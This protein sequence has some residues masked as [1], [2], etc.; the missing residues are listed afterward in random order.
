MTPPHRSPCHDC[1]ENKELTKC[2]KAC[3]KRQLYVDSF[4][5]EDLMKAVDTEDSY[6][7]MPM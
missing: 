5:G 7:L 3:E 6:R 1:D 2:A 4:K